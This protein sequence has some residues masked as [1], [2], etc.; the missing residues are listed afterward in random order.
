MRRCLR[1]HPISDSAAGKVDK[2]KN[3]RGE[4][5]LPGRTHPSFHCHAL[6]SGEEGGGGGDFS[7]PLFCPFFP[8]RRFPPP[9]S[10]PD[11]SIGRRRNASGDDEKASAERGNGYQGEGEKRSA[12]PLSLLSAPISNRKAEIR[13]RR[14][15]YHFSGGA[16]KKEWKTFPTGI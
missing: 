6:A 4:A 1:I 14:S 12:V 5:S 8:R 7:L 11:P 2:E 13:G 15:V 9:L 3:R 10:C 16:R